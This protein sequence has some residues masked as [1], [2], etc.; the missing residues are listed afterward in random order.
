MQIDEKEEEVRGPGAP[1]GRRPVIW[2]CSAIEGC[3]CGNAKLTSEK[4]SVLDKNPDSMHGSF[5]QTEAEKLF[6]DVYGV[7]PASVHGP[8][9]DKK[10]GQQSKIRRKRGAISRDIADMRLCRDKKQRHGIWEGWHGIANY[11]EDDEEKVYFCFV[12]E[13]E[14]DPEKTKKPPAPGMINISELVFD[15]KGTEDSNISISQ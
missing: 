7:A 3:T 4:I 9:Y 2:I 1:K 6:M 12:R 8:M 14:P 10:G 15:D 13:V 11:I 5:P